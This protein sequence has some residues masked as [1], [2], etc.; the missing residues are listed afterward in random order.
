MKKAD[1]AIIVTEANRTLNGML[2]ETMSPHFTDQTIAQ[3]EGMFLAIDSIK[4]GLV[5][6]PQDSHNVWMQSRIK[7]GWTYGEV[8][9][10]KKKTSPCLIPYGELPVEQQVKDS[11]FIG[12]VTALL[13]LLED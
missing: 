13:P 4:N 10:F 6:T 1:I 8:K 9:S 12:I 7:E 5:K 11:L 2:G 3:Q